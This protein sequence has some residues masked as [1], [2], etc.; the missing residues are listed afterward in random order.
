MPSAAAAA[1]G[2][3]RLRIDKNW[4]LGNFQS[5]LEPKGGVESMHLPTLKLGWKQLH[6]HL[7]TSRCL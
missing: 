6:W 1:G 5:F 2:G 3:R 7:E 4:M